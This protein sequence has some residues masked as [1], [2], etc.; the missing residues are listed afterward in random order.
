MTHLNTLHHFDK[1]LQIPWVAVLLYLQ[2]Q[3]AII[4]LDKNQ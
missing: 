1:L 3:G 2:K 4:T